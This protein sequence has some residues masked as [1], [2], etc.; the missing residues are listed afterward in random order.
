MT[1]DNVRDE[2]K[3]SFQLLGWK[4]FAWIETKMTDEIKEMYYTVHKVS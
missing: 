3:I 2:R 1:R 4:S